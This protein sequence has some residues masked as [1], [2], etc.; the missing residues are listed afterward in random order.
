MSKVRIL[1]IVAALTLIAVALVAQDIDEAIRLFNSYH[2]ERSRAIFSE[3][4]KDENNPR[5]AEAFYYLGRLSLAPDSALSYYRRVIRKYP[6]SRY[7]D[8]AHLEIAKIHFARKDFSNAI[9]TLNELLRTFPDTGVKDEVLFWL[10]V[11]YIS[12]G[13]KKEGTGILEELRRNY[14]KSVWSERTLRV[15]PGSEPSAGQEYFTIQVGSYRDRANAETYAGEIGK[16]GFDVQ[17]VE[18]FVKGNTY[19][20]V[21]V[22]KF[23]LREDADAFS[24]KLNALGI[25]GNVVKS[26]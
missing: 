1:R 4:V 13:K 24:L 20:R 16:Q 11:S 22:G 8:V 25:K 15:I 17:V 2:F 9:I 19:F 5:V 3:V 14:P 26:N 21:W 18:A 6:Q 12:S 7:A 23:A 10:G